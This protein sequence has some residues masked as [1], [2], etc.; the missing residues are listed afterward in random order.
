MVQL[1]RHLLPN[2]VLYQMEKRFLPPSMLALYHAKY[3]A[4]EYTI[5][6]VHGVPPAG[7]ANYAWGQHFIH[8]IAPTELSDFVLANGSFPSKARGGVR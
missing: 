6:R 3:F 5:R 2:W 4:D 7:N 8:Y 1:L